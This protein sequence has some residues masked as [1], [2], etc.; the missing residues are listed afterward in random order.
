[1]SPPVE[2]MDLAQRL[3]PEQQQALLTLARGLL[4]DAP[5]PPAEDAGPSEDWLKEMEPY[6]VSVGHVD[7]SRES[8][9]ERD[10]E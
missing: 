10:G 1:M 8:I 3:T 4:P 2:L 6:M 5:P 7:D 9:Y